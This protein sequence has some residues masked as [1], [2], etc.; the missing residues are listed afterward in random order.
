MAAWP[1]ITLKNKKIKKNRRLKKDENKNFDECVGNR[2][3]DCP[4]RRGNHGVV[5][6]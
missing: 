2:F 5:H 6:K 4:D 1:P 3:V